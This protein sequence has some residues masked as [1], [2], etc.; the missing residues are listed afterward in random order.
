MEGQKIENNIDGISTTL[1]PVSGFIVLDE[2]NMNSQDSTVV[3][4]FLYKYVCRYINRLDDKIFDY[5]SYIN[6]S[7][8][9]HSQS[10]KYECKLPK[11]IYS[12]FDD[13]DDNENESNNDDDVN[14]R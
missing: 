1:I 3:I 5:L 8:P 4:M 9:F 14:L 13:D 12:T 10:Q 6:H 2:V 7:N 11:M